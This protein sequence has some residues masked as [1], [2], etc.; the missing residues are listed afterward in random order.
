MRKA[1][2]VIALL[3]AVL[4]ASCGGGGDGKASAQEIVDRT[5]AA[6]RADGMVYHAKG[7]DGSE[8][9]IDDAGQRYRALQP[10][11]TELFTAVGEGWTE[12]AYDPETNT[13]SSQERVLS[14]VPRINDPAILW[15]EPL[16]ALA[17]ASDITNIGET[18]ADGKTVF[19][20]QTRTPVAAPGQTPS[21]RFLVGRLELDPNTYLLQAFE[22]R[23]QLLP[24]ETIDPGSVAGQLGTQNVRVRY[25]VSELIPLS[26]LPANFFD[27]SHVEEQVVTLEKVIA[28]IRDAGITPHWLGEQYDAGSPV[29][30]LQAVPGG[31]EYDANTGEATFL[32]GFEVGGVPT[33]EAVIIRLSLPGRAEFPQPS[34]PEFAPPLPEDTFEITVGGRPAAMGVSVL[35]P[36]A[37]CPTL[38]TCPE[39]DA[40]LFIRLQLQLDGASVQIE[41]YARVDDSGKEQNAYNTESGIIQLAEA[42]TPA[43]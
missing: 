18:Q 40:P 36:E 39:A 32:Y 26:G 42:L 38:G 2:G 30:L 10:N 7:S 41:T 37:V 33:G 20:V 31:A 12:T 11:G 14:G 24:G 6:I 19:A 5:A 4:A 17:N 15:F 21:G 3:A 1:L 28:E 8:V 34:F 35:T 25:E 9:W 29:L 13:V 43:P 22:R 16:S 27:K 23:L